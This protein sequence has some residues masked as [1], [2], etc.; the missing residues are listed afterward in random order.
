MLKKL[1][2][3]GFILIAALSKSFALSIPA[4]EDPLASKFMIPV[5]DTR[6]SFTDYLQLSPRQYKILTGK[7]LGLL[8]TLKFKMAQHRLKRLMT[9]NGTIDTKKAKGIFDGSNFH[10]GGYALGMFLG[11]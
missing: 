4:S 9:A 7:K 3:A 11:P 6:I 8:G 5:G 1:F 10:K 2:V